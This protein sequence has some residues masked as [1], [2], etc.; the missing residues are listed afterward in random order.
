MKKFFNA[1]QK[2][3]CKINDYQMYSLVIFM[4]ILNFLIFKK[5]SHALQVIFIIVL[6]IIGGITILREIIKKKEKE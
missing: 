5:I 6:Y 3:L 2:Y 1:T 4:L